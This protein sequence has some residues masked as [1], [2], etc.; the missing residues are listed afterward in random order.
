ME[1]RTELTPP[2][3]DEELVARLVTL[4]E[5]LDG[6]SN[7]DL[8]AEFNSLAGTN[9]SM[10]M[11]QGVYEG[12]G[13]LSFVQRLLHKQ[14]VRPVSDVTRDELVE[15]VRRAMERGPLQEAYIAIFDAN[16]PR[17]HASNLIHYPP[18][19]DD[20][21]GTWGDGKSVRDYDPSPEQIV[22]WALASKSA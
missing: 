3:L 15:I 5:A 2:P 18:D 20:I 19:Y 9:L 16:V 4:A 1:L 10:R 22:G 11:F 14:L 12:D 8:R 21:S 6:S 17:L 13:H 7:E